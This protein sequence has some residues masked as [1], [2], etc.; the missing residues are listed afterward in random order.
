MGNQESGKAGEHAAAEFLLNKGYEI[1]KRN[2]RAGRNELDIIACKEQI[3]VFVEIKTRTT[4]VFGY[5]EEAVGYK[6]QEHIRKASGTYIYENRYMG[7]IRYDIVSVLMDQ[8]QNVKSIFHIE[9][10]FFPGS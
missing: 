10:A 6:K 2:Y 8:C 1:L 3:L 4:E 9:D 5:P 7:E